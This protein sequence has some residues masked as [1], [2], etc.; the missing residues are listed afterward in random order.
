MY[1]NRMLIIPNIHH[2]N[3]SALVLNNG[4][5]G[6]H[7]GIT[8]IGAVF[9]SQQTEGAIGDAG[10]RGQEQGTAYVQVSYA[11]ADNIIKP[12]YDSN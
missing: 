5:G 4:V 1:A 3:C 10:Q 12:E 6:N 8:E 9:P 11:H 7:L 2:T